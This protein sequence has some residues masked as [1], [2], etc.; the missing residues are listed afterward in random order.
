MLAIAGILAHGFARARCDECGHDFLIAF[1]CK[2]RGICPSCNTRRRQRKPPPIWSI[3]SSPG[4]LPGN[5]CCPYP[6]AC[7]TISNM[8]VKP[9]TAYCASSSTPSSATCAAAVPKRVRKHEP[10][11]SRSS[12]GS[13]LLS[14]ST[15]ILRAP[16]LGRAPREGGEPQGWDEQKEDRMEMEQGRTTAGAFHLMPR[17]A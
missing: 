12:T 3:M 15:F 6:S 17:C 4:F 14:T 7:A 10:A 13:A 16:S 5:G 2:G 9:S 1:S 11:R 8:I